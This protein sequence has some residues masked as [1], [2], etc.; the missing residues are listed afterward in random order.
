MTRNFSVNTESSNDDTIVSV[1]QPQEEYATRP[2]PKLIQNKRRS[3]PFHNGIIMLR[4]SNDVCE[5][6]MLV[7][8]NPIKSKC[9]LCLKEVCDKCHLIT[10]LKDKICVIC[11]KCSKLDGD[12]STFATKKNNRGTLIQSF[13]DPIKENGST[14]NQQVVSNFWFIFFSITIVFQFRSQ[15]ATQKFSC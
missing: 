13:I 12:N 8:S 4:K 14:D 15:F 5:C 1:E 7:F 2:D 6:C 10:K 11:K 3:L 9:E